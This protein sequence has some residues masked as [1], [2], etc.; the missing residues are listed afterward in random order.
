MTRKIS[1]A[2]ARIKLGLQA[3]VPI[4]NLKAS[5]DWGFAGDYVWAMWRMLQQEEPGD[6][7]VATGVSHTIEE[8]L[9]KAFSFLGLDWR[10]HLVQDPRFLRPSEVDSLRGDASKARKVLGWEPKV[11]FDE[12]VRMMVRS[13]LAEQSR[14][15]GIEVEPSLRLPELVP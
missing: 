13:D 5:R 15:A 1:L 7:V 2:A 10:D 14:A 11:T 4:G 6:Y 12:L 8:L 9:E 3:K